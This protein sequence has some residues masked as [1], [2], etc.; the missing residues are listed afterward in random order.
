MLVVTVIK[1]VGI[2][3]Q[4]KDFIVGVQVGP[5]EQLVI[6]EDDFPGFLEVRIF[7]VFG[8][9][10]LKEANFKGFDPVQRSP[11]FGDLPDFSAWRTIVPGDGR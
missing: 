10:L 5:F 7:S 11:G 9:D 2:A 1:P 6:F 8:K 4:E 3:F